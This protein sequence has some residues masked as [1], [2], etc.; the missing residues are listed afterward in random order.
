MNSVN[1]WE[2][3]APTRGHANQQ[4]SCGRNPTEGSETREYGLSWVTNM[5]MNPHERGA[6]HVGGEIVRYSGKSQRES[7]LKAWNAN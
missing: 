6:P 5:T 4:P 3:K 1:C 2:A 7:T